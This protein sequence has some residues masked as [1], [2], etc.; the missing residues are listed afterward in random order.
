MYVTDTGGGGRP[1]TVD[2]YDYDPAT[3]EISRRSTVISIPAGP[4]GPDGMTVDADGSLW[5]ALWGHSAVHRHIPDG[6]LTD[7][8]EVPVSQPSSCCIGGPDMRT[9]VITTARE[10]LGADQLAA[11]PG[12]G[13]LFRCPVD[14]TAPSADAFAG[15]LPAA[16]QEPAGDAP[17]AHAP[18]GATR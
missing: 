10:G 16:G 13:R 1:G 14:V 7:I 11:Q 3:G 8:V 5:I 9:L 15:R 6:E 12:A 17:D 4:G 2:A 18:K